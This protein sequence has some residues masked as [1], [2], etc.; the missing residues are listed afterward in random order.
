MSCRRRL[1][2]FVSWHTLSHAGADIRRRIAP[3]RT[4][5]HYL[6]LF[7]PACQDEVIADIS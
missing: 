1:F 3:S 6:L 4:C 5:T 7:T 2:I